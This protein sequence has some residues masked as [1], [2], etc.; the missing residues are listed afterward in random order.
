MFV[1][2]N[3]TKVHYEIEGSGE[4][5]ILLLHGWG[6]GKDSF[7]PLILDLY[8]QYTFLVPEMPGHGESGEPP[9]PWSVTE[10]ADTCEKLLEQT[11]FAGCG[12]IAHSFGAR[13]AILL[14]SRRP[15][16]FG[17]MLLTGAAGLKDREPEKRSA[18][19]QVFG[20]LKKAAESRL[21]PQKLQ[22]ALHETAVKMFGSAD[23]AAASPV[24][25]STLKLV[26]GQ[27]LR[28]RLP[29]IHSP[30]FLFWGENDT[31]TPIWM[32]HVME[33]E[34]PDA[35]LTVVPGCDHFAYLQRH[36]QFTAIAQALFG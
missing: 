20:V 34:I 11:G 33:K 12:V 15:E 21:V 4:K 7:R 32:A 29:A 3:G 8:T 27:D 22:D 16:L 30:V 17:R 35:A 9:Y 23:Y 2:I 26:I 13:I 31:A 6:G 10:Y 18:K 19:A 25:R 24:M 14:A 28:D 36:E 5:K 1:T